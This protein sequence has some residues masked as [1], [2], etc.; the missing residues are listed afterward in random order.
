MQQMG[1]ASLGQS[2]TSTSEI[3]KTS[4][5]N[6]GADVASTTAANVL[7]YYQGLRN[8]VGQL[9]AGQTKN[10]FGLRRNAV[11]IVRGVSVF[12]RTMA[13]CNDYEKGRV[14]AAAPRLRV[15]QANIHVQ[16]AFSI[17]N[18]IILIF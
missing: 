18:N 9:P 5:F 2:D 1:L 16:T 15:L 6:L 7:N 8:V 14:A 13:T 12:L 3:L 11:L 10:D 4:T 17:H